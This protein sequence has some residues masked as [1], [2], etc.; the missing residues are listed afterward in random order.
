ML[1]IKLTNY[2]SSVTLFFHD[3]ALVLPAYQKI[4]GWQDKTD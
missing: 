2:Y 3:G 4:N 1:K